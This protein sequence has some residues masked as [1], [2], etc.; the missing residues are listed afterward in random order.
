M[1]FVNYLPD[2][3]YLAD[4]LADHRVEF[5]KNNPG[6]SHSEFMARLANKIVRAAPQNYL[7]FGPYWWAL[8]LALI[9]RGYAYS[10]ELEPLLAS[11][12]SGQNEQWEFD[13]DVTIVAAFEFAEMYDATQFQGVRQFDL[14]G[15]GEFYVLMDESV[16]MTRL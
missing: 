4:K 3:D 1:Q 8:K 6:Q 15:N 16:E 7:R 5:E 13:A 11:T 2:Q 10:G 9:A 12:Y 14:F